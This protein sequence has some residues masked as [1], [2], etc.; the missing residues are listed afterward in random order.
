MENRL[1]EI[2]PFLGDPSLG[3]LQ[4]LTH[5]AERYKEVIALYGPWHAV[6]C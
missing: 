4:G 1:W 2:Y 3:Y 5:T 6:M